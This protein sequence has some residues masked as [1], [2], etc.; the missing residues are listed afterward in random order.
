MMGNR[1]P[2]AEA[3]FRSAG[4][5]GSI[6]VWC[7][8]EVPTTMDVARTHLE[9]V[10]Y[11][12]TGLVFSLRQQGGRGRRGRAWIP[13]TR[14]FFGTFISPVDRPVGALGGFPLV[15][16]CA[17]ARSL[18]AYRTTVALKWPNDVLS[19]DGRKLGGVLVEIVE[20]VSGPIVLT[21]IGVNLAG[22][23]DSV[24]HVVDL[25]SLSGV[26]VEA[27]E[28]AALLSS[29]FTRVLSHFLDGGFA[30]FREEWS[31]R[32]YGVGKVVTLTT[33]AEEVEGILRGVAEDGALLVETG[34]GTRT[35]HAGEV[36][37][38]RPG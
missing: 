17:V 38:T 8:D 9:E 32:A 3:A 37:T 11:G 12:G 24:L 7:Y 10:P 1:V 26:S 21:G 30:A 33:G 16:G 35:F 15:V 29:S 28:F 19:L 5:E 23:P 18:A 2:I 14:G 25:E 36:V 4:E 34:A 31:G 27:P 6:P 22:A 13:P 20:G